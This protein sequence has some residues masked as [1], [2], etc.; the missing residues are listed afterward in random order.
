MDG[1]FFCE[2][3]ADDDSY[4]ETVNC[5]DAREDWWHQIC[6]EEWLVLAD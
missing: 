2:T 3:V 1:G 6:V 4:H 5:E